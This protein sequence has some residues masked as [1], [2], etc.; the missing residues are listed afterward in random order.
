MGKLWQFRFVRSF[1]SLPFIQAHLIYFSPINDGFLF[2]Y[3]SSVFTVLGGRDYLPIVTE[4]RQSPQPST[5]AIAT[6]DNI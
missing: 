5:N 2:N 1:L 6:T 4:Y 3:S